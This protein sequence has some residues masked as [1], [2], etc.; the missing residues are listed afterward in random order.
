MQNKMNDYKLSQWIILQF[1]SILFIIWL[2]NSFHKINTIKI[3]Y[4]Q[5]IITKL[6]IVTVRCP[7]SL[8]KQSNLNG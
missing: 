7:N 5:F 1:V 3:L 8:T 2:T 6:E 4:K